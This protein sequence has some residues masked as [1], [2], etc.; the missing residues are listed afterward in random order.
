MGLPKKVLNAASRSQCNVSLRNKN[1][2]ALDSWADRLKITRSALVDAMLDD[3][4]IA[5][6]CSKALEL[7]LAGK[8][9][10][11][12][13]VLVTTSLLPEEVDGA[14]RRIAAGMR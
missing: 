5:R 3:S 9:A 7:D 12:K 2:L 10:E 6:A 4:I 11:V 13:A 14:S 8:E 1:I